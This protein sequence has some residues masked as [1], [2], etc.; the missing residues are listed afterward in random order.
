MCGIGGVW[1]F[2]ESD[3]S[4][5]EF[6]HFID[7]LAHRGPDGRG[8]YKNPELP[9]YLG[10]RR[11]AILDLSELATQPMSYANGRFWIT[12]NGEIYNFLELRKELEQLGHFFLSNSDTEVILA[13][14]AEWGQECQFKFNGMW[15]FAIWDAKE[16]SLFLSRDRFGVKPLYFCYHSKRLIFASELKAFRH[17]KGFVV[18]ADEQIVANILNDVNASESTE[19]SWIRGVKSLKAGHSAFI[20]KGK[21][22]LVRKWWNTLDHL[23]DI[24]LEFEAQVADFRAL[25]L[26]ACRLRMRSDVPIAIA[27]SGGLDSSS[28]LAGITHIA[29]LDAPLQ[30]RAPHWRQVFTASYPNTSQDE[31][32]FAKEMALCTGTDLNYCEVSPSSLINQLD[33]ILYD[34]ENVF[35]LPVG[36][37][38]LYKNMRQ[39][40]RVIS[41]DGHGPDEL[42][43]GYQHHV[44]NAILGSFP[45]RYQEYN[46]ILEK[47]Y[48]EDSPSSKA[49]YLSFFK[50]ASK[51]SL[52]KWPNIYKALQFFS[53]KIGS[54]SALQSNWLTIIPQPPSYGADCSKIKHWGLFDKTLHTDFHEKTMPSIL[55]NF[56]RCSMAHG[57]EIRAPFLDWRLVCYIFALSQ[58]SKIGAGYTKRILREAMKG[59]LPET[60]RNRKAKIGFA[61]PINEWLRVELKTFMLDSVRSSSFQKS[62]IWDG[63]Q[64]ASF[65]EEA[66]RINQIDG[67]RASW[68]FVQADRL[69]NLFKK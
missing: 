40:G 11:L 67:V 12:F 18:D 8:V 32:S 43:G 44:E 46:Q 28:I 57:V 9:L 16:K 69:M 13:S 4:L 54:S 7:S 58:P 24:P 29:S 60:I 59:I 38:M 63:P 19:F 68:E 6:V 62:P 55:R 14:Y 10:H 39:R 53:G 52:K 65:V 30:R 48:P 45:W 2:Y 47:M 31:S 21:G 17:L 66:Y 33:R 34:S 15:A 61:N 51:E 42:L 56:D 26:D 64:I 5:D 41:I 49:S 27:L 20:L 3:L 35:D 37:W 25:F 23:P 36:P 50:K 1:D 22:L